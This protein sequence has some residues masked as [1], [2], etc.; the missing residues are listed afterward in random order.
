MPQNTLDYHNLLLLGS[1]I[2][3]VPLGPRVDIWNHLQYHLSI[4]KSY[5]KLK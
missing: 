1:H 2:L 5:G 4:M 3:H